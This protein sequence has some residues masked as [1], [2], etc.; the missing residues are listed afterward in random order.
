[1]AENLT[2]HLLRLLIS[3]SR[4]SDVGLW[5]APSTWLQ[6]VRRLRARGKPRA[7]R[8]CRAPWYLYRVGMGGGCASG[9]ETPPGPS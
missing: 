4:A 8:P 3:S 7:G 5:G 1:M 2:Q 6:G 9:T